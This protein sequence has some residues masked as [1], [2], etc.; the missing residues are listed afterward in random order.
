MFEKKMFPKLRGAIGK[1]IAGKRIHEQILAH[2][3]THYKPIARMVSTVFNKCIPVT[4]DTKLKKKE[5]LKEL[6]KANDVKTITFYKDVYGWDL[7][8]TADFAVENGCTMDTIFF[9]I[10][11]DSSSN[12]WWIEYKSITAN[13]QD[14]FLKHRK[15]FRVEDVRGIFQGALET[16]YLWPLEWVQANL[17]TTDFMDE[18]D[19]AL[20]V[21]CDTADEDLKGRW[22]RMRNVFQFVFKRKWKVNPKTKHKKLKHV[23][24][25]TFFHCGTSLHESDICL[26]HDVRIFLNTWYDYAPVMESSDCQQIFESKTQNAKNILQYM[27]IGQDCTCTNKAFHSF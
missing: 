26:F 5:A 24:F 2:L 13:R 7:A 10:N 19:D 6:V 14:V 16:G 4:L 20:S 22:N 11:Y 23:F 21:V 15:L 8:H 3:P 27:K 1:G 25:Q 17:K 18:M 12:P 9:L